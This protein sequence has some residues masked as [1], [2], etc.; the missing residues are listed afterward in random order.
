MKGK[1]YLIS[2]FSILVLF[3][4]SFGDEPCQSPYLPKI[5][6]QED[7]V[8]V[9]TLGVPSLG[10][11]S[12]KLVTID[13]NPRSKTYG[14]VVSYVSVSGRHE[15]HH[16]GFT[17]DRWY[18]WCGGL[19][20]SKI[21]IFDIGSNPRN[22]KLVKVIEDFVQKSGGVVGP[23]TFYAIPGRMLITGL[24]NNK[25]KGGKTALVE[26]TNDGNYIRTVWIPTELNG[27]K[28]DGYGYD[29]RVN[30]NL[31][32]ML[33]SSFT[34]HRNYM[35]PITDV[36]KD[37]TAT[38]GNT[39]VLWNFHA[40][41]PLKIFK[42]PGAPL[43][44]RWAVNPKH[45]YAFTSTALTSEL[46][47]IYKDKDGEWKAKPV[48]KI[49]PKGKELQTLPLDISIS[50]DD[51]YI[52]VGAYDGVLRIY[53]VQNPH[54]PRLI[55]EEKVSDQIN[56]VS[57]SW[58]GNR[59]Y[60]TTSLLYNWDKPNIPQVLKAYQWDGKNLKHLFTVDFIKEG[61]GRPHHM[62]FGQEAYYKGLVKTY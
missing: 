36:V 40:M 62:N 41:K 24:S 8:Y 34:G 49:G 43:E 25:D 32:L 17:E 19:D 14:K 45:E 27:T 6:G 15:A 21:F 39:M 18:L 2:I 5:T 46:W 7:Y 29:V 38:F 12:D 23:H 55:K 31:N 52:F 53:D 13:V 3:Y 56:M 30:A 44:I 42:V 51:R 35:R 58:D 20:D 4:V 54:K 16:C 33:T 57:E 37:P 47:L 48:A 61:L 11:G 28:G 50:A 9:W 1:L 22:P 26:Y 59:I 10:D 60:V